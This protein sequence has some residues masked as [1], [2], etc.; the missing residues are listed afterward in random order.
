MR[1]SL[2]GSGGGSADGEGKNEAKP[3][4]VDDPQNR[5]SIAGTEG[6]SASEVKDRVHTVQS[7]EQT[8]M[9]QVDQT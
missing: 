3:M 6:D 2:F 5:A 7:Q 9:Q 4:D 1:S 8:Q